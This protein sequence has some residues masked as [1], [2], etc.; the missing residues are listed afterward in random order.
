MSSA[1]LHHSESAPH[2]I[3]LVFIGG[4]LGAG[5]TRLIGALTR[6]W[7]S[8]GL[9][10]GLVAAGDPAELLDKVASEY[11]A[12]LEEIGDGCF[13]C[14]LVDLL[15]DTETVIAQNPQVLICEPAGS[16]A[17][18]AATVLAPLKQF[19][20]AQFQPGPYVTVL[21]PEHAYEMLADPEETE[22]D[23]AVKEM[24]RRQIDEADIVVL[25]K[26]DL[27]S[28]SE[29]ELIRGN[30]QAMHPGKQV[31]LVSTRDGRGVVELAETLQ[32][33]AP[34][35][36]R[37]HHEAD[38]NAYASGGTHMGWV[39]CTVQ[40]Q[41]EAPFSARAFCESM[42]RHLCEAFRCR[43]CRSVRLRFLLRAGEQMMGGNIYRPGD[44]PEIGGAELGE[45]RSGVLVLYARVSMDPALLGAAVVRT[46]TQTSLAMGV[47]AEFT[48]LQ[49]HTPWYPC[50]QQRLCQLMKQV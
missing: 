5:K 13:A 19:Y 1:S 27:L 45:I 23:P 10:V 17:D 30:L 32:R 25:N 35:G 44:C 18:L 43:D 39:S 41:S 4:F 50:P 21:D 38:V 20:G 28:A 31:V 49:S 16:C 46:I 40:I 8:D 22:L 24:Y 34:A 3:R 48:K 7:L 9:R 15:D 33:D 37:M 2:R 11:G 6:V 26:V 12:P 29:A 14:R 47:C 42:M 36:S